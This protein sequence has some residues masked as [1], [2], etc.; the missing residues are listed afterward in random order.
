MSLHW[1]KPE[2]LLVHLQF[3]I[4]LVK[5]FVTVQA[6]LKLCYDRKETL[7]TLQQNS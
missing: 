2:H 7:E 3:T 4:V 5:S 1:L 6:L